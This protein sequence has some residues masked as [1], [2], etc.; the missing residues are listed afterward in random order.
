MGLTP[1]VRSRPQSY[2]ISTIQF[3]LLLIF[4]ISAPGYDKNRIWFPI[5]NTGNVSGKL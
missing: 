1:A 2:K 3:L 4:E 5:P